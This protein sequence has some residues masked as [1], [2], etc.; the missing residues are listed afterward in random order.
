MFSALAKRAKATAHAVKQEKENASSSASSTAPQPQQSFVT[1]GSRGEKKG[2]L[3]NAESPLTSKRDSLPDET[4]D[5]NKEE[6]EK[7]RRP[8]LHPMPPAILSN[9]HR[10]RG[11]SSSTLPDI[12]VHTVKQRL[13]V[14]GEPITLFGEENDDRLWRYIDLSGKL[15]SGTHTLSRGAVPASGGSLSNSNTG[16]TGGGGKG[17]GKGDHFNLYSN[18]LEKDVAKKIVELG[19][20][21]P[22]VVELVE[23]EQRVYVLEL[24]NELKECEDK[25]K[26]RRKNVK[27][28][29]ELEEEEE[30]ERKEPTRKEATA[31]PG[32]LNH[33]SFIEQQ[34]DYVL[35]SFSRVILLWKLTVFR[36]PY[37][38][39]VSPSTRQQLGLIRNTDR[40]I[41]P[42]LRQLRNRKLNEVFLRHFVNIWTLAEQQQ[43]SRAEEAYFELSIGNSPWIIGVVA[44]SMHARRALERIEIGNVK[45]I[46]NNDLVRSYLHAAKRLLR[47]SMDLT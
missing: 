38:D 2:V 16:P 31:K 15:A 28:S 27:L 9:V 32:V 36:L 33:A 6:E 24:E 47:K 7:E 46:L 4:H 26:E 29:E 13:R 5:F 21:M 11:G 40:D 10:Q 19:F 44:S 42:L 37:R 22:Q 8:L 41:A 17:G 3:D 14:L 39:L 45:H 23:T 43:Y 1:L 35:Y 20:E 18:T 34:C 30:K 25:E 12:P